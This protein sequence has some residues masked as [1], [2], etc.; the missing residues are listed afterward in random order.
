MVNIFAP[1]SQ[2]NIQAAEQ[3]FETAL[4]NASANRAYYAAFHAA[5]AVIY[6]KGLRVA[7]DHEKVQAVFNGELIH[8]RKIFPAKLRT[9]LLDMHELREEADYGNG[10][11]KKQAAGQLRIAR[12]CMTTIFEEIPK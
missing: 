3:L 8:R 4:Y 5:I 11:S 2:E 12:E 6:A 10:V 1:R 7:T 9:Y